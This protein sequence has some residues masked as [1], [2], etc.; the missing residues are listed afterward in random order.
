MLV[1]VRFGGGAF[2]L[3]GPRLQS[4]GARVAARKFTIAIIGAGPTL[5]VDGFRGRA[6]RHRAP[7]MRWMSLKGS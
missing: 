4:E 6:H 7:H 1:R 3:G 5:S 2:A